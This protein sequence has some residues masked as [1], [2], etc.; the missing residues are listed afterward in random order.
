M[1]IS[2]QV[3]GIETSLSADNL[4]V[5]ACAAEEVVLSNNKLTGTIPSEI[6][7]LTNLSKACCCMID[8]VFSV[9]HSSVVSCYICISIL[10]ITCI[11]AAAE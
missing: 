1:H 11:C 2:F 10:Q 6:G 3:T 5:V 4:F 8:A 7:L 9:E